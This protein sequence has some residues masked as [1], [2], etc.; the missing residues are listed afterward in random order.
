MVALPVIADALE[1]SWEGNFTEN[2]RGEL[3][4]RTAHHAELVN[5]AMCSNRVAEIK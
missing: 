4:H 3:S 1:A 2:L 5:P